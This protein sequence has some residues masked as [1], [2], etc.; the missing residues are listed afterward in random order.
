MIF[1]PI[2]NMIS[3]VKN[4]Y[5]AGRADVLI[6]YSSFKEDIAKVLV[7]ENFL[8]AVTSETDKKTGHKNLVLKLKYNEK[9]P[10]LTDIKQIS[11]TSLRVYS[12]SQRLKKV[13][14]GLGISIISTPKGVMSDRKAKK[15]NLGGEII[16][17]VW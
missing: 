11:K 5:R 9:V 13:L 17:Q 12:S 6:P 16:C 10:N 1:D 8:E 2:A 7:D 4:G 14:G 3:S 15:Q